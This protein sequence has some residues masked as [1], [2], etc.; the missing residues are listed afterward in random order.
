ML[1]QNYGLFWRRDRIFWGRGKRRGHLKGLYTS[2]QTG[3]VVDF[4]DQ[5]GIYVLYDSSFEL[6][7]VGQAGSGERQRLFLRLKQHRSDQLADRWERFSWFGIR[8]VNQDC[9]LKVEKKTVKPAINEVLNHIEAIL[10]ASA[11]PP[12]N[13]QG[14]RFGE[15]VEQYL[16]YHDVENIGPGVDDMVRQLWKAN[17]ATSS[18]PS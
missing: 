2:E 17:R 16:Q 12:H 6:V 15:N 14:G 7:Y 18:K 8:K 9:T 5:Q 1:V 11:E 13:R 4:R 10:I 3:D